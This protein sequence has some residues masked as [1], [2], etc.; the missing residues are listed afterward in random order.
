MLKLP[1]NLKRSPYTKWD[2]FSEVGEEPGGTGGG[3]GMGD[4]RRKGGKRDL[5]NG[6]KLKKASFRYLLLL[7]SGQRNEPNIVSWLP[8]NV[9]WGLTQNFVGEKSQ[10][11]K[12]RIRDKKQHSCENGNLSKSLA[13]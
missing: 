5:C 2:F 3:R 9:L 13:S 6:G 7:T 4:G 10:K 1:N 12:I 11:A 8:F